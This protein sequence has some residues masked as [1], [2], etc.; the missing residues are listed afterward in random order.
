MRYH[1]FMSKFDKLKAK[2]KNRQ[3]V[4]FKEACLMKL[5]FTVRSKGSHHIFSK[6]GYGKNISLKKVIEL[7]DYQLDL[8]KEALDHYENCEK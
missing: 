1:M 4:S 2:I 8:I 7:L 6:D 5:G 3:S